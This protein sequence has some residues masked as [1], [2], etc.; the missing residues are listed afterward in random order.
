VLARFGLTLASWSQRAFDTRVGDANRVKHKL[1]G[2][3]QAGAILLLHDG[4]AAR[5]SA[6]VPVILE[7]LP[8]LLE[9]AAAAD[10]RPVTLQQAL[11]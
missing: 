10:L 6:G 1:L 3:L 11:A 7:V 5:T 9:A 4:H 8:G 2:G